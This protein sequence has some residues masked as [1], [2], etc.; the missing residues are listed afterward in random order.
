MSTKSSADLIE[1]YFAT[2]ALP[3]LPEGH[4]IDGHFVASGSGARMAS[5]DPGNGKVF[6]EFAAGDA[7]DVARA[8]ESAARGVEIW[9]RTPPAERCRVLN[10]MAAL[11][12][13]HAA[14]L[15]VVE[16]VDS[17]KTLAEAEG[18]VSAPSNLQESRASSTSWHL[19]RVRFRRRCL[20]TCAS[21]A[22]RCAQTSCA[23]S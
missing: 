18:D 9:R 21:G 5:V 16:S 14:Y 2:G 10:R 7:K 22:S 12:R 11:M 17:G 20:G 15:S 3:G 8:V 1:Q 6:A 19:R 23:R 13:E 4:L